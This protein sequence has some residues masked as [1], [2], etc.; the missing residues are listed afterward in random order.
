MIDGQSEGHREVVP[1]GQSRH[2][3]YHVEV[4]KGCG[5]DAHAEIS[6]RLSP[7]LCQGSALLL[8][9]NEEKTG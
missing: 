9:G 3:A 1:R 7:G 4:S 6:S 5:G 2:R 8:R